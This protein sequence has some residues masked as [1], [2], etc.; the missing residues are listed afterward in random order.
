VFECRQR[1]RQCDTTNGA[2]RRHVTSRPGRN[3]CRDFTRAT[4]TGS[5]RRRAGANPERKWRLL[6]ADGDTACG[7]AAVG[8]TD[9]ARTVHHGPITLR[10]ARWRVL[11]AAAHRA[12]GC[13]GTAAARGC[14]FREGTCG[15]V[16]VVAFASKSNLPLAGL[17]VSRRR[18]G[19]SSCASTLLVSSNVH[20]AAP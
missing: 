13:C 20:A 19:C 4:A 14:L 2:S 9:R 7:R 11:V 15:R 16:V 1:R 8:H 6:M 17:K 3:A 10:A 12:R 5:D 18:Q